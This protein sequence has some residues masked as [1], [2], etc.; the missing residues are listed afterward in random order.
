MVLPGAILVVHI[1][2][3]GPYLIQHDEVALEAAAGAD[4]V[5]KAQQERQR[6]PP[7]FT[8]AQLPGSTAKSTVSI[9]L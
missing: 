6:N 4:E 3:H 2:L 5:S 9:C 7:P 1:I 8:T